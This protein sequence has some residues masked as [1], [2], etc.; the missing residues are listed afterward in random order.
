MNISRVNGTPTRSEEQ[1]MTH[2]EASLTPEDLRT[3]NA[4]CDEFRRQM[5]TTLLE[6]KAGSP[7]SPRD[8]LAVAHHRESLGLRDRGCKRNPDVQDQTC[9]RELSVP[10]LDP[11][12]PNF[13]IRKMRSKCVFRC[14]MRVLDARSYNPLSK[15]TGYFSD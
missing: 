9:F 15:K 14:K 12:N 4:I 6:S 10:L 11:K 3:L 1:V 2:S 13:R 8:V 5:K 7:V